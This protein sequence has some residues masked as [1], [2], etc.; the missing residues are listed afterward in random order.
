MQ[1]RRLS[2]SSAEKPRRPSSPIANRA[3]ATSSCP[4]RLKP[5]STDPMSTDLCLVD[6]SV[7]QRNLRKE[8]T[9]AASR[10]EAHET[11]EI[12]EPLWYGLDRLNITPN[13]ALSPAGEHL[14][15]CIRFPRSANSSFAFAFDTSFAS[16]AITFKTLTSIC[17]I[18]SKFKSLS[19]MTS[20]CFWLNQQ[21]TT[22]SD[23]LSW[24]VFF[25][26]PMESSSDR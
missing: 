14:K 13:A 15:V 17:E 21:E 25:L 9:A 5:V 7:D 1:I 10:G 16:F 22:K 2:P 20:D 6:I 26:Q 3:V 24:R 18:I 12:E 19:K 11:V 23:A 4:R 8:S